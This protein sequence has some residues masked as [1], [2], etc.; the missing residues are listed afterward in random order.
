MF[1]F[2]TEH[3]LFDGSSVLPMYEETGGI[4]SVTIQPYMG[5]R[6]FNYLD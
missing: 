3:D 4:R 5:Y 6:P 2:S 1:F